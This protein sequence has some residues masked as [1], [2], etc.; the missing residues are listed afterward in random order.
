MDRRL[1]AMR[2]KAELAGKYF[3]DVSWP[4]FP[5]SNFQK[6]LR[7]KCRYLS[8]ENEPRPEDQSKV[9]FEAQDPEMTRGRKWCNLFCNSLKSLNTE[10]WWPIIKEYESKHSKPL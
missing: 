3:S 4:S 10:K 7:G 9:I 8:F 2:V 1:K 6:L 5:H